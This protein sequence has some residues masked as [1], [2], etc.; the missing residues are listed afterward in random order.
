MSNGVSGDFAKLQKLAQRL[1]N[2]SG[3]NAMTAVSSAM[4][5]AAI[6]L[7]DEGFDQERDPSGRPWHEKVFPD[8]RA[9]L[10]GKSGNLRRSFYKKQVSSRGFD[11]AS[12][13]PKFA[14]H[15]GG[16]GKYGPHGGR[17]YP[18][19]GK[20]LGFKVGGH[21][22]GFASVAGAPK[23]KM[24]PD[25]GKS[26]GYWTARLKTRAAIILREKLSR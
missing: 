24:L 3:Q 19:K 6:E 9:V 18:K 8:G 4:A 5:D 1:A 25:A 12:S 17:I 16:T 22:Y 21:L 15:Q 14:F 10:Q 11:V 20:R 2:L 23:R 13:D 7:I 26:P